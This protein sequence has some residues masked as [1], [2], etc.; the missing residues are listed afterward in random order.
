MSRRKRPE[1]IKL[2]KTYLREWRIYKGLTLEQAGKRIGLDKSALGR[3]ENRKSPF[4]QIHL[5]QLSEVYGVSIRDLL[6]TE[7]KRPETTD[8]LSEL[9]K[10]LKRPADVATATTLAEAI[11]SRREDANAGRDLEKM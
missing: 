2:G 4:D 11:L 7:P 8:E 10:R 1:G 3:I 6:S 9:A 5:Q